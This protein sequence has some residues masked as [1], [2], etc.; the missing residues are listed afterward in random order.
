MMFSRGIGL[1]N[2]AGLV[3]IST[4]GLLI[5][6]QSPAIP[7]PKP[8]QDRP[9]ETIIARDISIA[10]N[11]D[12][13]HDREWS[14]GVPD[15]APSG[16][17]DPGMQGVSPETPAAQETEEKA[18]SKYPL[19]KIKEWRTAATQHIAGKPDSAA[20]TIGAWQTKDL[21]TVIAFVEKLASQP[22]R[23]A[24]RTLAKARF[25][26]PLGLTDQEVKQGDLSRVLR[27]GALLHTDIALLVLEKL[28]YQNL[29]EGMGG[30]ADGL[31]IIQPKIHHWEFAR[32]LIDSL[33][34]LPSQ[35]QLVRQWYTAT[36]AHMQSNR[37]LGYAGHNLE[38]ALKKF[39]EDDR[40]LFYAGALH[41]T[42][43]SP[44]N[45]NVLLPPEA[46]TSYGSRESELKHARQFLQKCIAANPGFT[47]ARLHLGRVQGLLG[48]HHRAVPELQ[49]A[50]ASMQDPLLLY[51]SS[52]YL[53]WE[54]AM[55][56]RRSEARDQ[57]QRA[58]AL[59]P[60]AQS[61]L[62]ALSEL[63]HSQ[64]DA[65]GALLAMQRV[66]ALPR[67][68]F[69]KDDPW[70]TYDLSHVRDAATLVAEMHKMFGGPPK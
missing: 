58:A 24:K 23:S 43:A 54:F 56:S 13:A 42:W 30:F 65:E 62:L 7:D 59:Y 63:A 49:Q 34:S 1:R 68:D 38:H 25:N 48:Q 52:L 27:Q 29:R 31:A 26:R 2:L 21:E 53:G 57:Y 11:R 32:R 51:Y 47:E 46:K 64:D 66:F 19:E 45:Q 5:S 6:N 69:R 3:L 50:A 67:T 28:S 33:S 4:T 20:I 22:L 12:I 14:P 18:D 39:P 8:S 70:W 9:D 40:I 35:N 61:P 37:D 44:V 41:E 36:T 16:A 60:T 10:R 17:G 55:L 15:P